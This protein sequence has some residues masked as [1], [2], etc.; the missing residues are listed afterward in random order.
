MPA[1]KQKMVTNNKK[2]TKKM[3]APRKSNGGSLLKNVMGIFNLPGQM[4]KETTQPS[5]WKDAFGFGIKKRKGGCGSCSKQGQGIGAVAT[6]LAPSIFDMLMKSTQK[7]TNMADYA[8][9]KQWFQSH[10][11][12]ETI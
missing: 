9:K 10:L 6:M 12:N 4:I 3:R 2:V 8:P 7:E 11:F 5:F 1:K